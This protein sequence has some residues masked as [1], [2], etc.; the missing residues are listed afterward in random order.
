MAR[1][2]KAEKAAIAER[3]A[4]AIRLRIAG[5]EPLAIGK[6]LYADPEHNSD[7]LSTPMGYGVERYREGKA[8]LSDR[9]LIIRVCQDLKA[10]LQ[11]RQGEQEMAVADLRAIE[12]ARLD[13]YQQVAHRAVVGAPASGGRE[14]IPSD[15]DAINVALKVMERRAR[16]NG[17]DAPTQVSGPGGGNPLVIEIDPTLLPPRMDG[18]VTEHTG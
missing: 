3:R 18:D 7:G 2:T 12:N 11:V 1:P 13:V 14:A 16:L 10:A 5:V 8:P 9:A 4:T 15:P 17:L 6:K